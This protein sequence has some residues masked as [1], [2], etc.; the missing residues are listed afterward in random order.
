[1]SQVIFKDPG[2]F[3]APPQW[4]S[5]L[6]AHENQLGTPQPRPCPKAIKSEP[7]H[8][9]Y[10]RIPIW[11]SGP[12]GFHCAAPLE[13]ARLAVC[14]VTQEAPHNKDEYSC[15]FL[16]YSC[17]GQ[18]RPM[19]HFSLTN[20]VLGSYANSS[21]IMDKGINKWV[22]CVILTQLPISFVQNQFHPKK[23]KKWVLP[24]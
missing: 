4:F 15:L 23:K 19:I 12:G 2:V 8:G 17:R 6:A 16:K 10:N 11:K 24:N 1:M 9:I 22:K 14:A 3:Q 20:T 7:W 13:E 5:S 18:R 21:K